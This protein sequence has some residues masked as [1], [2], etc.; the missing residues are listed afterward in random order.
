MAKAARLFIPRGRIPKL[1]NA[2]PTETARLVDERDDLR[3]N[4]PAD[5]RIKDLDREAKREMRER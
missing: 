4:D 5:N 2:L 1:Y 3:N